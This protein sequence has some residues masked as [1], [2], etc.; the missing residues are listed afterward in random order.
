MSIRRATHA[1]SWYTDDSDTLDSELD[2]WLALVQGGALEGYHPPIS[3][4]K[5]VIAP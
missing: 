5:A 4:C 2:G 1:G 3:G